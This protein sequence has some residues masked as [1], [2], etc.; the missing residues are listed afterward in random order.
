MKLQKS[1]GGDF[2][3]APEGVQKG[4]L[5][6]IV[7]LGLKDDRFNPGEQIPKMRFVF[8]TEDETDDGTPF[9]VSTYPLTA[10]MNSKSN[11]FGIVTTLLGRKPAD[12]DFD[13]DDNFDLDP[14][15][16]TNV[17]I[18]VIHT[19]KDAKVFANVSKVMPLNKK[20]KATLE[21]R[22]Y[23]RVQDRVETPVTD[24]DGKALPF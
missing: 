3:P 20:D 6:D 19:E 5:V 17:Q 8:Q 9:L 10:S 23:V 15:I 24:A 21:P 14:L 1:N 4:V 18:D 2:Q 16:G 7:D 13:A 12:E 11:V 22:N